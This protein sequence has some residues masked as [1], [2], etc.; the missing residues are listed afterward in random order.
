MVTPASAVQ[1][2]PKGAL[3]F[4]VKDNRTV[5]TRG[6]EVVRMV[7]EQAVLAKGLL[8]GETVVTDGQAKLKNGAAVVI[9]EPRAAA[10]TNAV[11]GDG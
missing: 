2:G 1:R 5:E 7:G 10:A 11:P 3:V 6:V 9:T 4:V 8:P